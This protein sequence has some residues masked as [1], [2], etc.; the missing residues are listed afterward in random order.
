M[1]Y[2]EKNDY[3]YKFYM[4]LETGYSEGG[5]YR[6]ALEI[7]DRIYVLPGN[8]QHL[9]I[10]KDKKIRRIDFKEPISQKGAF[11][12]YWYAE[13]YIFLFPFRYPYFI[14][15]NI[16]TEELCYVDGINRFNVRNVEGEWRAGGIGI[17]KTELV[18][19]SP[20]DNEFVFMD[21]NTFKAR[22]LSSNSGC[23]L[24]TQVILTEGDN[25]WLLPLNGMTLT[26]WNPKTGNIREYSNFPQG[27]KSIQWPLEYECGERPFSNIAFSGEG[28]RENII[29]SPCWG[30][31][32]LSLNRETG[33]MEEWK[34]PM[35]FKTCGRNGYFAAQGIGR[36]VITYPQRGKA[37]CRI[38]YAPE[39]KLYEINIDTGE[40]KEVEIE[41][42]YDDLL[43]NEAGFM[44]ESEWMQYCLDENAFNSLKNLLD[45]RIT[46]NQ[47]DRERQLKA[48]SKINVDTEGTCG[49]NVHNFVKGKIT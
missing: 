34:S 15:F 6:G 25:L 38:W 37:D 31:M 17:Y 21:M 35:K 23:N 36:F 41:F 28:S 20:V 47:F 13:K 32:Y 9:L 39:R 24:G 27:F 1:W 30:N 40:Y 19:A 49:M 8:A 26:C 10:I 16:D 14:R 48:F 33:Q 42:D 44:E 18:F 43:A 7:N 5:Y 12:G 46:G 22:S 4:D 45:G 29:L 3:H 2:S 11:F